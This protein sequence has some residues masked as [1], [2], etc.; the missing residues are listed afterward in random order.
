MQPL[1]YYVL[2][3]DLTVLEMYEGEYPCFHST[4][5]RSMATGFETYSLADEAVAK[6]VVHGYKP[7]DF[8]IV[9][10]LP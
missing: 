1:K 10:F 8:A 9:T 5:G 6:L 2:R 7:N 3:R 4:N